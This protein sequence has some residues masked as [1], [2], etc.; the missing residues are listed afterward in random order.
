MAHNKMDYKEI[1][2][3]AKKEGMKP[4]YAASLASIDRLK[5]AELVCLRCYSALPNDAEFIGSYLYYQSEQSGN[6]KLWDAVCT[7]TKDGRAVIGVSHELM[8][9]GSNEYMQIVF[10]HELTHLTVGGHN[11]KF[12]KRY[13]ELEYEYFMRNR[14]ADGAEPY[15]PTRML[16]TK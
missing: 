4:D 1:C 13:N 14:R 16:H 12:M 11:E 10:L 8:N 2:N 3:I 15:R 5:Q 7:V 6:A 9:C